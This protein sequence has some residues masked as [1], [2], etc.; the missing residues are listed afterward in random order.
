MSGIVQLPPELWTHTF[1]YLSVTDE[2]A[3]SDSS[4]WAKVAT[5]SGVHRDGPCRLL[6]ESNSV[7]HAIG[8][9]SRRF[10]EL[11]RPLA[12]EF[13]T[14]HTLEQVRCLARIFSEN[15][16]IANVAK[17][18]TRRLD[19]HLRMVPKSEN[20]P[21][22]RLTEETKKQ[23]GRRPQ[24]LLSD[25]E[26]I[27]RT[28]TNLSYFTC[29]I[30]PDLIDNAFNIDDILLDVCVPLRVLRWHFK[31]W[32]KVELSSL[33]PAIPELR[34]LD[35]SM[36]DRVQ[37][38]TSELYELSHLHTLIGPPEIIFPHFEAISLPS[39]RT[40]I[41]SERAHQIM[42]LRGVRRFFAFHGNK[43]SSLDLV[44]TRA[45]N[46]EDILP[47]C[48]NVTEVILEVLDTRILEARWSC[49]R[50]IGIVDS[51]A[52]TE[53]AADLLFYILGVIDSQR[54]KGNYL[55]LETIRIMQGSVVQL[56]RKRHLKA[57]RIHERRLRSWSVK[58][59]D[60]NGDLLIGYIMNFHALRRLRGVFNSAPRHRHSSLMAHMPSPHKRSDREYYQTLTILLQI[61]ASAINDSESPDRDVNEQSASW[62]YIEGLQI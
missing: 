1:L 39:I 21:E 8:L 38:V 46:W 60:D 47:L 24:N 16:R 15:A 32:T 18:W 50:S 23:D 49:I 59:E 25:L 29:C 42:L 22:R 17:R 5:G 20:C 19:I 2:A 36:A 6:S 10:Y 7:K 13:I 58:L 30:D 12:L 4:N 54:E 3:N 26:L 61:K 45:Y 55:E 53:K 31:P 51:K 34:V 52:N 28:C 11:S 35:L 56:L 14:L 40:V 57:T 33:L 62:R 37:L 27:I 43:I 48:P 9:V 41:C 44:H